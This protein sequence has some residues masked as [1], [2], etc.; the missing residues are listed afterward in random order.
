[1]DESGLLVLQY[2]LQMVTTTTIIYSEP[3]IKRNL[4]R[5]ESCLEEK[6]SQ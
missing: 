2:V 3:C 5:M 4:Y 1:M 6:F